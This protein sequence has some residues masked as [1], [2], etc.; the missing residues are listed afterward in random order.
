MAQSGQEM[1]EITIEMCTGVVG[2]LRDEDGVWKGSITEIIEKFDAVSGTFFFKTMPSVPCT[3]QAMR[4]AETLSN[5]Q[6]EGNL[7]EFDPALV[8]L[9]ESAQTVI[10]K[11]GMKGVT[12][13]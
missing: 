10:E 3:R 11:A 9:I 13:T 4:D 12:L 7:S 6:A 5:I 2:A 1:L 8:E